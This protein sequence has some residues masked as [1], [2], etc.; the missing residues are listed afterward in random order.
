VLTAYSSL[1]LAELEV[2]RV[3]LKCDLPHLEL[4][5]QRFPTGELRQRLLNEGQD[6]NWDLVFGTAESTFE[7]PGIGQLL[8]DLETDTLA[9]FGASASHRRG[10]WVA[11][12]GFQ[13][14]FLVG[15]F[16]RSAAT[17]CSW[18][19]LASSPIVSSIALP[20][21]RRSAAGMLNLAGVLHSRGK[22][23]LDAILAEI[24]T[25]SLW[26]AGTSIE[27]CR[28]VM[29]GTAEIGV[30]VT[31]AALHAASDHPGLSIVK[32][33][34]AVCFEREA[35]GV[36]P[37]SRR[38]TPSNEVL[39]WLASAGARSVCRRF[40]KVDLCQRLGVDDKELAL[41]RLND[42]DWS[43]ETRGLILDLWDRRIGRAQP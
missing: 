34:D 36:R 39:R 3:A 32:P 18:L 37:R 27:P 17:P 38:R 29:A 15:E 9:A 31:T 5:Y 14:A 35:F 7:D 42:T 13:P 19:G 25:R 40:G 33:T 10:R 21:P 22:A 23:P 8:A 20:D 12:T 28:R 2:Y 24:G 16:L 30:T 11:P 1:E 4:R 26:I 41:V 6:G 43:A